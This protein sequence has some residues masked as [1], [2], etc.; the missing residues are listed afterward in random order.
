MTTD[1]NRVYIVAGKYKGRYGTYLGRYGKV[2]CSV[3]ID[4][5]ALPHRNLWMS[6]ITRLKAQEDNED[7]K[8]ITIT[9]REMLEILQTISEMKQKIET[10]EKRLQ[11][12][13]NIN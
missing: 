4:G 11:S 10:L 7:D 6:S 13:L 5:D 9:K 8:E 3:R 12:V 1:S 2:M